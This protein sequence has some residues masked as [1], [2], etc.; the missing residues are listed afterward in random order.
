M[1]RA[2]K[3]SKSKSSALGAS[4]G[5]DSG[6]TTGRYSVS[7]GVQKTLSLNEEESARVFEAMPCLLAHLSRPEAL[8]APNLFLRV[9]ASSKSTPEQSIDAF[10]AAAKELLSV[11]RQDPGPVLAKHDVHVWANVLK[12]FLKEMDKPLI[13]PNVTEILLTRD[14][15]ALGASSANVVPLVTE[16]LEDLP[17]KNFE[18]LKDLCVALRDCTS[19]SERLT[20]MFGVVLLDMPH[21][22]TDPAVMI[23]QA[24]AM[25]TVMRCLI[26]QASDVFGVAAASSPKPSGQFL[27]IASFGN[28]NLDNG[29]PFEKGGA[30]ISRFVTCIYEHESQE[31]DELYLEEGDTV[32]VLEQINEDWYRGRKTKPDGICEVGIFPGAYCGLQG[33]EEFIEPPEYENRDGR[34]LDESTRTE[35]D[36]SACKYVVALYDYEPREDVELQLM[37]GELITLLRT[38]DPD[39]WCGMDAEG[40]QGL[41]PRTYVGPAP[42]SLENKNSSNAPQVIGDLVVGSGHTPIESQSSRN[43][44]DEFLPPPKPPRRTSS[45]KQ[46]NTKGG[47]GSP[48]K[49]KPSQPPAPV[50][51]RSTGGNSAMGGKVWKINKERFELCFKFFMKFS[52][53]LEDGRRVVKGKSAGEF[54][55]RS[56]LSKPVIARILELADIDKDGQLDRDEFVVA[57]HLAICISKEGMPEPSSLP[58]YLIPKTKRNIVE[59]QNF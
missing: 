25:T 12:H 14:Y 13:P 27:N 38:N 1:K 52:E 5:N 31:S 7:S 32:K 51:A 11:L 10:R 56:K 54:L 20:H 21:T 45:L 40:K 41:F 17:Y 49:M 6:G 28:D 8:Q 57:H 46:V 29:M 30:E 4:S 50:A 9:N 43:T 2:F 35:V 26:V 59:V 48:L 22:S 36:P 58:S 3:R 37:Q 33:D 34:Q 24:Q 15:T 18:V 19:D 16:I 42:D 23:K 44:N 55:L 47:N 53:E 39:W